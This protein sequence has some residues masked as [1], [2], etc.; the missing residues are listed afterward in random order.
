[1]DILSRTAIS[2][3]N[4]EIKDMEMAVAGDNVISLW[5]QLKRFAQV[6]YP[7]TEIISINPVGLKG[8]FKDEYQ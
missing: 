2:Q 3:K 8:I 6:F 7:N 4:K 5:H 1:M